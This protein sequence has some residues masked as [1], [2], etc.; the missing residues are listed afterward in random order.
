M[1]DSSF[2]T[3]RRPLP[4]SLLFVPA[5]SA[6]K[7]DKAFAS[8]ADGVIVDL[9]DAV[10]ISEKAQARQQAAAFLQTRRSSQVFLRVNAI[11][12][13][14]CYEDLMVA[15][16]AQI[17]GI[18]LPKA[19]S[20]A[21]LATADWLLGQLERK[22]GKPVGAIEITPIIETA[23]GLAA[24]AEIARASPRL[25]RLA[26]GAVDLALDMDLD[27]GDDAGA[28]ANARF[29]LSLASRQA[30]LEGPLD[31]VYVDINDPDGLRAS[32]KRARAMGFGGKACIHPAQLE[33]VNAVFTPSEEE[34]AR[35][36]EVVTAFD[37]AE[38][39]GAAAVSVGGLMV[40]YPMVL[41]ARR[42]LAAGRDL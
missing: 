1:P 27:L 16:G 2:T 31:T 8:V 23:K 7:V 11:S 24:A 18:V 14:Y 26:F 10:A 12:S 13:A 3:S 30:G 36:R 6:R 41:K 4:R 22:A 37:R 9:E 38:A 5:T 40:D 35:A 33:V 32:A 28:M 34:L 42:V 20:S 15:A 17:D 19:E 39:A 25:R 29:A 21:E